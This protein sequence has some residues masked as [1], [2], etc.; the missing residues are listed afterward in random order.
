MIVETWRFFRFYCKNLYVMHLTQATCFRIITY[1]NLPLESHLEQI[2]EQVMTQFDPIDPNTDV[3]PQK[4]WE[5]PVGG[6]GRVDVREVILLRS[7]RHRL[8]GLGFDCRPL[9]SDIM[10]P[11]PCFFGA[12]LLSRGDGAVTS[13]TLWCS[14]VS[15]VKIC[16]FAVIIFE[17]IFLASVENCGLF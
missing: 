2:N 14:I 13:C 16:F 4:K 1:G 9:K 8:K 12:M 6:M 7:W 5:S 3:P 17:L 11:L 15:I 10:S